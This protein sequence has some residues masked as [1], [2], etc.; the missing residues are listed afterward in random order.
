MRFANL[1]G[2]SPHEISHAISTSRRNFLRNVTGAAA[3]T[4]CFGPAT[5]RGMVVPKNR[6]AVVVTFG[7][8]ARDDETF[9]TS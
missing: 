9:R 7:G 3:A 6:K 2:R 8:G 5:L 4:A 1:Q